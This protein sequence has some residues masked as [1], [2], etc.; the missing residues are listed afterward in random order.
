M[1]SLPYT[2]LGMALVFSG[3]QWASKINKEEYHFDKWKYW[4]INVLVAAGI[5]VIKTLA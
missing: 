5:A 4:A 2:L 1:T 3:V